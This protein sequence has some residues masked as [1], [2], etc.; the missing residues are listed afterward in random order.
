MDEKKRKSKQEG[1]YTFF[2]LPFKF[3][4]SE[5]ALRIVQ[6]FPLYYEIEKLSVRRP[7]QLVI[8]RAFILFFYLLAMFKKI[9]KFISLYV[10]SH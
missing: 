7:K 4:V 6:H 9:S 3:Y 1:T 5:Q 2:L 10:W 8:K